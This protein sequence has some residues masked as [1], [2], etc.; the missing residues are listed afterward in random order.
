[1]RHCIGTGPGPN[2]FDPLSP[3]IDWVENDVAPDRIIATHYK[4]N[5]PSTG[6]I[7]STMPLCP[8]PQMARFTGG[9]VR[10]GRNW[11]CEH[12]PH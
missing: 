9:N 6:I 11:V 8:Y 10:K 12:D 5:D 2:V 1:M 4:D 7:T 3:L